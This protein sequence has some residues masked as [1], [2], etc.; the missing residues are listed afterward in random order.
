M[1]HVSSLSLGSKMTIYLAQ[2]AQIALLLAEKVTVLTKYSDFANV[3]SKE[4]AKVL[5]K[6]TGIS[7]DAIELENGKQPPYGPIYSLGPVE[8]ET[9]KTYIKINLANGFI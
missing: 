2:K 6:R 5:P 9:L 1:V 3:F 7:E 4:L 8:L